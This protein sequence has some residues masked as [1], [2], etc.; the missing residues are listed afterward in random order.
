MT[1]KRLRTTA[2]NDFSSLSFLNAYAPPFRSSPKDSTTNFFSLPF[3]PPPEISLFWETSIAITLSR[4]QKVLPTPVGRKH[5]IWSFPLTYS[6]LMTLAYLVFFIAPLAF[7]SPLTSP[8]LFSLSPISL[9]EDALEP[10]HL[11]SLLIVPLS[12]VFRPNERFPSL[13]FQKARWDDFAFYFDSHY[14]SSEEYSSHF[15]SS[16]AV[17]FTSLTLNALLTIWRREVVLWTDG[18]VPFLFGK[19]CSGVLANCSLCGTETTL[20]FSA[21]PV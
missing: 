17:L 5:S 16:A 9:L 14:S 7:A 6:P 10:H 13:N 4:T 19:D 18:S 1:N 20:F 2:L 12:T 11:P 8:L 21:G 15:L 3:F